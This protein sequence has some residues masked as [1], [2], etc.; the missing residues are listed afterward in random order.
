MNGA[1]WPLPEPGT[2]WRKVWAR[3]Y[4]AVYTDLLEEAGIYPFKRY[5]WRPVFSLS[6]ILKELWPQQRIES[7]I[8]ASPMMFGLLKQ[9][10]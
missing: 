2:K 3:R 7:L 10:K 1:R 9:L 5:D 6:D 8:Y 4:A